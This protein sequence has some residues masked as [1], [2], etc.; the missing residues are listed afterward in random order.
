[1][2]DAALEFDRVSF[3]YP[4]GADALR[5]VTL[6]V[7]PGERVGILGPNGGGKSTLLKLALGLLAPTEGTIRVFDRSAADARR[8]RLIGYLPQRNEAELGFPISARQAVE[9][10][11]SQGL[12]PF[13]SSRAVRKKVDRA[14]DLVGAREFAGA[15]VGRLSGGQLQRVLIAR[16]LAC[17]PRVLALDEPT[18]GVDVSG[19]RRFAEMLTTLHEELHLTTLIVTHDI[20]SVALACDRVACLAR[21]LH[22]HDAPEG[23]TPQVLAEVFSHDVAAAFGDLH[24]DAHA[25][26]ACDDPSHAHMHG[27][28]HGHGEGGG[29]ADA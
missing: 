12:G 20:R 6:R 23:L 21:T 4:G 2:S 25:A 13:T 3:A 24:V 18:V 5:A 28:G 8:A 15:P 16:A 9:L 26:E 7:E 27:H 10:A 29:R 11:A 1:M 22:F 19:Q 17:D 14:L